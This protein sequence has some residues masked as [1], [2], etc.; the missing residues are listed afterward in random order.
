MKMQFQGQEVSV[1]K[2]YNGQEGCMCGCKG[3]YVDRDGRAMTMRVK[4][5]QSFVGPVRPD[6]ANFGDA[7]SYSTK[8]FGDERYAYVREG[9]RVTCVYFR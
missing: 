2:A 4:K 7:V 6:A 8:P 5:V 9:D 1:T 3:N